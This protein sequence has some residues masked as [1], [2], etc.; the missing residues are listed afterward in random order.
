MQPPRTDATK[1]RPKPSE[2]A[3]V[4]WPGIEPHYKAGILSISSIAQRFAV[5]RAGILKHAAKQVPPWTRD[6]NP[7][8]LARATE[9]VTAADSRA[10]VS[11]AP[12]VAGATAGTPESATEAAAA[13]EASAEALAIVLLGQRMSIKRAARI[14]D[15]MFV[16]LEQMMESPEIAGQVFDALSLDKDT[17]PQQLRDIASIITSLPERS[18]VVKTLSEALQRVVS[19]ER[20]SYNLGADEDNSG[21]PEVIVRDFTGRGDADQSS[22]KQT[23]RDD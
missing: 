18:R 19:L 12:L 4:D 9:L 13:I 3:P 11:G 14:V 20:Q 10:L 16:E 5:S 8:V 17:T 21:M 1:T 15:R 2:L 7:Q 22:L 23:V 6:K